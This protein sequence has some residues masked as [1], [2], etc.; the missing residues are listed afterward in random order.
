MRPF[1]YSALTIGIATAGLASAE[2]AV[3]VIDA[4]H[5]PASNFLAYTE[6]ELSG[7]PLAEALGLDLDILDVDALN[8]PTEFDY[9]AGVEAYEYSE[10]AM[11]ALNYQ[12]QMGPHLVNG[13]SNATR[14]GDFTALNKRISTFAA[15]VAFPESEIH[16]NLYPISLPYASGTSKLNIDSNIKTIPGDSVDVIDATGKSSK[17]T[18]VIPAYVNDYSLVA[19]DKTSFNKTLSPASIGGILLKEVMWSQDFL[20]GMHETES[21]EEVEAESSTQ[22]SGPYS[23]GVSAADG[24]QGLLLTEISIDKMQLLQNKLAYDGKTLG[25]KLTPQYDATKH[26][27]WFPHSISVEET[28][29]NGVN[30]LGKLTINNSSSTL[31]DTWMLL[32]P[33]SEYYA[34]TDQRLQNTAQNPAFLSVFDNA[35]FAAAPSTNTDASTSNDVSANDAFSLASNLSNALFKNLDVLHFNTKAGTFV[36]SVIDGKQ[37]NT[38]TTFD[39][40]YSIV[41]LSIYQRAQDALPVGYASANGGNVNLNTDQ[42]KRA[43]ELISQQASFLSKQAK[44]SNGLI[45]DNVTIGKAANGKTSLATQFATIRGLIAAALATKNDQYFTDAKALFLAVEKQ[46]FD[47]NIG[48]WADE[49]GKVTTHTPFTAAAISGGLREVMLHLANQEKDKEP[50]LSLKHL[51]SRYVSWFK[52]VING[53]AQL[54]EWD[55]ETGEHR[56]AKNNNN[57]SDNDGVLS[58][59]GAGYAPTMA[60]K[61]SVQ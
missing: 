50:A 58:I 15:A 36:D 1:L 13:P 47:S 46:Q 48:T 25:A 43:L 2:T 14:G 7:E 22:D 3:N 8:K 54:A 29:K 45:A 5:N 28:Q 17:Q 41:A 19:W 52:T 34:F 61:V 20:G 6:F 51:T 38:I 12:S 26:P 18:T 24:F 53:G 35:P 31:Q 21:D 33:T 27:I 9:T 16:A 39:A 55:A 32:W 10:E 40:A 44:T 23:L 37:S 57:D 56:L 49:P 30:A 11:Y 4:S 42:G 60:N 59:I